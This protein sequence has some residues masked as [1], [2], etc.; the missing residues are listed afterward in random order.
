MGLVCSCGNGEGD[1]NAAT[2][3]PNIFSNLFLLGS[4]G[5]TSDKMHIDEWERIW[6]MED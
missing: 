1:G 6:T 5:S 3:V 2:G 4:N